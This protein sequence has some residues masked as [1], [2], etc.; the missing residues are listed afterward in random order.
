[1]PHKTSLW[2]LT[3]D[4][5][6]FRL[7]FDCRLDVDVNDLPLPRIVFVGSLVGSDA[8]VKQH[9]CAR[10]AK[11]DVVLGTIADLDNAQIAMPLRRFCLSVVPFTLLCREGWFWMASRPVISSL[12]NS[13]GDLRP[14]LAPELVSKCDSNYR[15]CR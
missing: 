2:W 6:R 14:I 9:L 5:V 12:T 15:C 3:T 11:A 13:G 10:R 4:C 8:F 7:L 1:V